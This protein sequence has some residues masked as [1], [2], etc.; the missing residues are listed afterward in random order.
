MTDEHD[1]GASRKTTRPSP[2]RWAA[3]CTVVA[4]IAV[5]GGVW[6]CLPGAMK[7]LSAPNCQTNLREI[8]LACFLWKSENE[9]RW[10][11]L[12]AVPGEF[13]FAPGQV[14]STGEP[15]IPAYIADTSILRCPQDAG[16]AP[17]DEFPGNASYVYLGPG[18]AT[19]IEAL[20][21]LDTY[22]RAARAGDRLPAPEYDAAALDARGYAA[23]GLMPVA[24]DRPENHGRKGINVLY[25]DGH[26][27]WMEMGTGYPATVAFW[28]RLTEVEAAVAQ[29][30]HP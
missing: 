9:G 16:A 11:A 29:L 24:F 12:S 1:D 25:A 7:N 6:I 8:G 27:A 5:C 15:L 20:A 13:M 3:A 14:S 28:R 4:L 30:S 21:F 17:G 19:E 2:W 22:L 18:L 23:L 10:P 26:V